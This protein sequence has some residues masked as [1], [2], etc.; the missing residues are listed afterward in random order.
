[1]YM[2]KSI[3]IL[4]GLLVLI[5]LGCDLDLDNQSVLSGDTAGSRDFVANIKN[6]SEMVYDCSNYYTAI[7]ASSYDLYMLWKSSSSTYLDK[8]S[9]SSLGN[10]YN[11]FVQIS[12]DKIDFVNDTWGVIGA[13]NTNKLIK[14]QCMNSS[15]IE[16]SY[17]PGVTTVRHIAGRAS[18]NSLYIYITTPAPNYGTYIRMGTYTMGGSSISWGNP[19]TNR[20]HSMYYQGLSIDGSYLYKMFN[21]MTSGFRRQTSIDGTVYKE[22]LSPY[23]SH[24][25]YYTDGNLKSFTPSDFDFTTY[26]SDYIYGLESINNNVI[27]VR[28]LKSNLEF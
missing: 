4:A 23:T 25:F 28:M 21:Y 3:M 7:A 8:F 5:S 9:L 13:D 19:S 11:D 10:G 14:M 22:S 15:P 6:D 18:G 24:G 1:M 26:G 12:L 2:K 20:F 16:K 17:P 27:V